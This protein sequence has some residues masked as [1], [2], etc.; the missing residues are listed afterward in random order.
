M[1]DPAA[2]R[3]AEH[4]QRNAPPYTP[5]TPYAIRWFSYAETYATERTAPF[6]G[7]PDDTRR[8]AHVETYSARRFAARKRQ[9]V[10]PSGIAAGKQDS[11]MMRPARQQA[12]DAA[13]RHCVTIGSHNSLSNCRK[14]SC[15]R[16]RRPP[17]EDRLTQQP[18][19]LEPSAGQVC[20]APGDVSIGSHD[21]PSDGKNRQ[22]QQA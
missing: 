4:T 13:A 22:S 12:W 2:L 15:K 19:G 10:A 16:F 18:F 7:H 11:C 3:M 8:I 14:G 21:T 6:L 20:L 9:T 1:P 5:V 17:C